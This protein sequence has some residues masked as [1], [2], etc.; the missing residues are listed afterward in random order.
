MRARLRCLLAIFALAVAPP[1]LADQSK[2]QDQ[3]GPIGQG[4]ERTLA[5]AL[6]FAGQL[7]E[8]LVADSSGRVSVL[9]LSTGRCQ[10]AF[11]LG[12]EATCREVVDKEFPKR[13]VTVCLTPI[14]LSGGRISFLR[15][16]RLLDI[17][18]GKERLLKED[19]AFKGCKFLVLSDSGAEGLAGTDTDRIVAFGVDGKI[20]TRKV[21]GPV[22]GQPAVA[23]VG[24]TAFVP[25]G[26]AA[27]EVVALPTL[28]LVGTEDRKLGYPPILCLAVSRD[29]SLL[30]VSHG[31]HC[32]VKNFALS[33]EGQVKGSVG[34]FKADSPCYALS[35]DAKGERLVLGHADGSIRVVKSRTSESDPS[36]MLGELAKWESSPS[37]IRGV[38]FCP[39]ERNI[40]SVA[41]DGEVVARAL[42]DGKVT[43]RVNIFAPKE[44]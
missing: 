18:K 38:G 17:E 24:R 25:M 7:N 19:T 32:R 40:V 34:A 42:P 37:P 5:V 21:A 27:W 4:K 6:G 13:P 29:G 2:G 35:Y 23:P 14:C 30:S 1:R 44:K 41:E 9:E 39:D 22:G 12:A 11:A 16:G 15:D 28:D 36:G 31:V 33:P 8:V 20:H 10:Q 3:P 43:W 26:D